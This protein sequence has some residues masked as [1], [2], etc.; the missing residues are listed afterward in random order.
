MLLG[1]GVAGIDPEIMGMGPV[2]ATRR[3]L[4]KV[5]LSINDIDLIEANEAFAAQYLAVGQELKFPKNKPMCMAA[6]LLWGIPS[7]LAVHGY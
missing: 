1:F 7:V 4:A 3:V 2:S 6:R 5:G